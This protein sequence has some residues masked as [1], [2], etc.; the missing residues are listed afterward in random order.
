[1]RDVDT[2]VGGKNVGTSTSVDDGIICHKTSNND[3]ILL[4]TGNN[5][6]GIGFMPKTDVSTLHAVETEDKPA[7][8]NLSDGVFAT[9]SYREALGGNS[10]GGEEFK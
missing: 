10:N 7:T 1:M 4:K 9:L 6:D 3:D 8:T 5:L 2:L